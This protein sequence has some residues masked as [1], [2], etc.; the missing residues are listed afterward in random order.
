MRIIC[1]DNY[2]QMSKKAANMI[3]NRYRFLL[4]T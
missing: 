3:A 4:F 2:E 1:V